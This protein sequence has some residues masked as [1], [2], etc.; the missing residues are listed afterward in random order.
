MKDTWWGTLAIEVSRECVV[1]RQNYM[2]SLKLWSQ[3]ASLNAVKFHGPDATV[4]VP[5]RCQY[6]S[7]NELTPT[8]SFHL[9]TRSSA[10]L[11]LIILHGKVR[12]ERTR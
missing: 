10:L 12:P 11:R 2:G 6:A 9:S 5:G 1:R 4:K 7:W 3:R 8:N